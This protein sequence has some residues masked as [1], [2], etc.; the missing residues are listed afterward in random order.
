M[1]IPTVPIF[2]D[3]SFSKTSGINRLGEAGAGPSPIGPTPGYVF[4]YDHLGQ[5]V[6]DH[7]GRSVEVLEEYA[8]A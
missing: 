5:Q 2:N 1:N 4:V 7:L 8:N 3:L 6:Y